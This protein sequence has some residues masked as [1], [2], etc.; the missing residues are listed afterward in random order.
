MLK[1]FLA[2]F[3][4]VAVIFFSATS[5][6][7]IKNVVGTG[8]HYLS[9]SDT[10]QHGKEQAKLLAEL[11]VAEQVAIQIQSIS[12][13]KNLK[14]TKDEIITISAALMNVLDIKYSIRPDF[15]GVLIIAATVTAEVDTEKVPE[16]V[17]REVNRRMNKK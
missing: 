3:L 5:N 12:E 7:E 1:N 9:K 14:L 8:E 13:L 17:E 10:L 15:D 11:D 2:A 6:A 4:F 16:L